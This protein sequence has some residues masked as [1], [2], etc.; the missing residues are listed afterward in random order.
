MFLLNYYL[1]PCC[2][3]EQVVLILPAYQWS[4]NIVIVFNPSG[5]Q[6]HFTDGKTEAMKGPG[7]DPK[8]HI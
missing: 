1:K 5:V 6:P 2:H 8:P 3:V 7:T 4:S